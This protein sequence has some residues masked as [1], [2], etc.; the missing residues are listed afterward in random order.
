MKKV[1]VIT[2]GLAMLAATSTVFAD[3]GEKTYKM[4]CFACHG[5]GAAGAP[6]FGDKAAWAPRI[7]QGMATLD[8]HAIKGFKA[9]PAK[10]G[11]SDLSDA[12]VK[13]AVAYMV[14]NSQ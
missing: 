7:K 4:A 9:M 10:G 5:T 12:D 8:E 1:L 3:A 13:A 2:A 14:K 6:K 11:R